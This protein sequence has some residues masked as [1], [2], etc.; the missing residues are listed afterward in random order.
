MLTFVFGD[1]LLT[2]YGSI[3]ENINPYAI[4]VILSILFGSMQFVSIT[5]ILVFE[6]PV[7]RPT[8]SSNRKSL[9]GPSIAMV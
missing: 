1:S 2:A 7:S 3:S 9:S 8:S 5:Q 6:I 4:V